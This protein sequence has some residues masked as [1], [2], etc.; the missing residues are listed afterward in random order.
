MGASVTL[1]SLLTDPA[2]VISWC[3]VPNQ[4]GMSS[5][6]FSVEFTPSATVCLAAPRCR[7]TEGTQSYTS[8]HTDH[9]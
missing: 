3:V 4:L 7:A 9:A 5:W 1:P 6:T 8:G 2:K